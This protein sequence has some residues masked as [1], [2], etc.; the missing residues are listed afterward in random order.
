MRSFIALEIPS[1]H[2]EPIVKNLL[3]WSKVYREGINW[4]KPEQLHITLNF[5]GEIDGFALNNLLPHFEDCILRYP[6]F[7]LSCLGFELFPARQP[8]LLW[9]KMDSAEP[10]IFELERNLRHIYRDHVQKQENRQLKL[11][12]TLCRIKTQQPVWRE[13]DFMSAKLPEETAS[14]D[15]ITLYQSILGPQGP[16]Y[17][18]LGKFELSPQRAKLM[19]K[20]PHPIA[21]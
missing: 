10:S 5:L 13:T 9:V 19:Q 15:T 8:R 11:H 16:R 18:P 4:V 3:K 17:I 21:E 6:P 12:A 14:Y 2:K 7:E 1:V 20:A